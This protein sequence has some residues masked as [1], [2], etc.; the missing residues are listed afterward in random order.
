M[1]FESHGGPNYGMLAQRFMSAAQWDRSLATALEWLSQ[2]PENLAAHRV[3]AQ[4]LINLERTE[5]AAPHVGKVLAGDPTDDFAH[6]LMAI[7]HFRAGRFRRADEAIRRAISLNPNDAF[8]WHQLAHMSYRQGDLITAKKCASRAR[9]LNPLNADI[10]NL[11]ILCEPN[12]P[13]SAAQKIGQYQQ[14]LA[15]DPE[16]A[17]LHNNLGAQ[18]LDKLKDYAQAEACFRRALFFEPSSKL[19]RKNL[20]LSLKHRDVVYRIL[21]A[22]KDWLFQVTQF[23]PRLRRRSV[24]LFLLMIPL[25]LLAF[26][27]IVAGLVLWFALVWPLIK[28]YEHLTV[29]DLRARAGEPAMGRRGWLGFRRWPL[30]IRLSL[31]AATLIVFWGGLALLGLSHG[32]LADKDFGQAILGALLILGVGAFF[33][34]YLGLKIKRALRAR[35]ARKHARQMEG[36]FA[37]N[38]GRER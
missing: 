38:P 35:A 21:C 27:F 6:R 20:F 7:I 28:V 25:W 34:Y 11:A 24:W 33:S 18:Y 29:D 15:L 14:A 5:E 23:F 31:F 2:E 10:L 32:P 26:R 37:V 9:T 17:N 36:L 8:H 3:A 4:S 1:A 30:K 12:G 22:P 16:N 13:D 19:F